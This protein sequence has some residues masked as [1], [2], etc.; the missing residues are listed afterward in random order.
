MTAMDDWTL[1]LR[2]A[3]HQGAALG[4]VVAG[5]LA[6]VPEGDA[7]QLIREAADSFTVGATAALVAY[8][9]EQT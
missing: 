9:E 1:V 4:L 7:G 3:E 6:D 8:R 5:L 2:M